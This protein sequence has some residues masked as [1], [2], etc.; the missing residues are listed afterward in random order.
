VVLFIIMIVSFNSAKETRAATQKAQQLTARLQA[1]G[2]RAPDMNQIIRVLGSDG[3]ALCHDPGGSLNTALAKISMSNGT[4]GPGQ[5][6]VITGRQVVLGEALA[7]GVYCPNELPQFAKFVSG[8]KFA[9]VI[10]T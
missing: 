5:R 1:A 4:S 7:I 3:G 8:L 9:P 10:R 6:P 2:L